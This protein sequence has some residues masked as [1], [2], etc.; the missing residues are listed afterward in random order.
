MLTR[1]ISAVLRGTDGEPAGDRSRASD[2]PRLM[3]TI[4]PG[5]ESRLMADMAVLFRRPAA[6]PGSR[7]WP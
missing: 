2:L 1:G 7:R 3:A 6:M 4:Y 5:Y